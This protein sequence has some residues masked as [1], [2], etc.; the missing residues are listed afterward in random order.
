MA[1]QAVK[2]PTEEELKKLISEEIEKVQ[3]LHQADVVT[4]KKIYSCI[5]LTSLNS[6]DG[7]TSLDNWI[8]KVVFKVLDAHHDIK[9]AAI[10]VYPNFSRLVSTKLKETGI[11]TAVVSTSFPTG[12]TFQEVK[13]L[14]TKIAVEQGAQE[15][16][17]VVS[18]GYWNDGF[19]EK[20]ID[21]IKTQ[22][23]ICGEKAH[24]KVILETC[25]LLSLS[26]IYQLSYEALQNGADFIK[27]STGKGKH[28]ATLEHYTVMCLALRDYNAHTHTDHKGIKAAGGISD[29]QTAMKFFTLTKNLLGKVDNTVFRIGAS[30]LANNLIEAI[31][32][33]DDHKQNLD[34]FESV[35]KKQNSE[36]Y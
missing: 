4:L 17:M 32:N 34:Q 3:N 10:C 15:I 2:Y 36:A 20:V 7:P 22:K 5:D 24:L 11:K 33:L 14:E 28:G 21:E 6:T 35:D 12:Q 25:E 18:R 13:D 8:D 19:Q 9:P 30:G 23:A 26:S 1:E 31:K 29:S 16:D 27:T